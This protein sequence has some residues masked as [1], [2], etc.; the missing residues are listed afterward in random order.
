MML[1]IMAG[2]KQMSREDHAV[3]AALGS[4]EM[5]KGGTTTFLD[6]LAQDLEGLSKVAEQYTKI[7]IRSLLTPMF[8]DIPYDQSLPEAIDLEGIG[9]RPHAPSS[10]SSGDWRDLIEM[11]EAMVKALLKPEKGISVAV[12]PSGPQRSSDDLLIASMEL[13]QKY[14]LPFHTHLLE[15]KAQEVTAQRLYGESMV[16][17]LHHLGILNHRIS[18]AHGVWVSQKDIALIR[19]CGATVVH[20]PACNLLIGSGIMPLLPLKEAGVNVALGTDGANCSGYQSMFESMKWAA[21]LSNTSTP[22]YTKWVTAN[23]VLTMA[24]VGSAQALGMSKS[25]GSIEA[26]KKADFVLL[27]KKVTNFVPLNNL[28]WQLVFGRA[29]TA[30]ASVYVNGKCVVENGKATLIDEE[31]LYQEAMERGAFLL[32]RLQDD[33]AEIKKNSPQLYDLLMRVAKQPTNKAQIF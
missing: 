20:N 26:G 31:S 24:T 23:D 25:I 21:L 30:I 11:V 7:G 16:E 5:L 8:S 17:H 4:I 22:D 28:T 32:K 14:D 2:G 3:S 18:F 9:A 15:T 19:D 27:D 1:Y 13:A 10:K 29:D 12:G 6:H 33:Y